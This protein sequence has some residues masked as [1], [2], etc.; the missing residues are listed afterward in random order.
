MF[1]VPPKDIEYQLSH[2]ACVAVYSVTLFP[3]S[4]V[5]GLLQKP[6]VPPGCIALP[7]WLRRSLFLSDDLIGHRLTLNYVQVHELPVANSITLRCVSKDPPTLPDFCGRDADMSLSLSTQHVILQEHMQTRNLKALTVGLRFSVFYCS[8]NDGGCWDL[9]VCSIKARFNRCGDRPI[10]EENFLPAGLSG[11]VFSNCENSGTNSYAYEL[12]PDESVSSSPV[13]THSPCRDLNSGDTYDFE[14]RYP[15][16][17]LSD[18]PDSV[19]PLSPSLV[20]DFQNAFGSSPEAAAFAPGCLEFLGN[21]LDYNGG[22]VHGVA[23]NKGVTACVALERHSLQAP[24]IRVRNSHPAHLIGDGAEDGAEVSV[25]FNDLHVQADSES[26]TIPEWAIHT[27]HFCNRFDCHSFSIWFVSWLTGRNPSYHAESRHAD[28]AWLHNL[29]AFHSRRGCRFQ[30]CAN[31]QY[32][33]V[34]ILQLS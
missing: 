32:M 6:T 30:V 27:V 3:K 22:P 10:D 1:V 13:R 2:N 26:R 19:S 4:W 8:K 33:S 18:A 11:C 21:H 29:S 28:A 16:I 31:F 20:Q 5:S 17:L 14:R 15:P 12:L 25:F 7:R 23:I 34:Q 9:E 24:R